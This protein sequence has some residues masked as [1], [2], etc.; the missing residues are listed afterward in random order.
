LATSIAET[1][2]WMPSLHIA[3]ALAWWLALALAYALAVAA[4][5]QLFE[6]TAWKAASEVEAFLG[7][8]FGMLVVFRNNA[9]ND[10]WWE[11]RKLW[12][13]LVNELR[14]LALKARAHAAVAADEHRQFGRL[15][16]GFAHALRLRL[17]GVA[18]IRAVPGFEQET[19]SFP[20]VPGYVASRIHQTLDRWN[21]QDKLH[22]TIWLLDVHARALMDVCGACERIR[23]TPLASSYRALLRCGVGLFILTAPWTLTTD[24]GWWS[25]PVLV[26]AFGFLLGMELTAEAIEEPFGTA[27]DD[28]PLET[29]CATIETFVFAE[30]GGQPHLEPLP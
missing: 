12:G 7:I 17:R 22:A 11:A 13:Q 3:R 29:F 18:G 21:R 1:S 8:A 23:Y 4:I 2:T 26:I 27:G 15:L 30:L 10:R 16:A 5:V 25:L 6:L 24:L 20:H 9:A 28:L 19:T 14:N